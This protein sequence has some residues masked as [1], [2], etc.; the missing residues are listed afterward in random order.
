MYASAGS[1]EERIDIFDL[2]TVVGTPPDD[3][4]EKIGSILPSSIPAGDFGL[5]LSIAVDEGNGHVFVL[6][7]ENCHL[8]EFEADGAYLTTIVFPFVC[9]FGGEIGVDNGPFSPNGKLSEGAGKSRYLYVPSHK[10]GIGHSFAFFESTQGPPEVKST[11]VANLGEDEA[12]LQALIDPN[13][14]QS[15]YVFEYKVEGTESWTP[16][17]GGTIAAS[18]L[19]AE[20]SAAASGLSAGTSYRFRVVATNEEGSDEAEGSFLTYPSVITETSPCPNAPLRS[21]SSALLPDCRAY[22]L[23]TPA[24]TNAHAPLGGRRGQPDPPGLP[25][26]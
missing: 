7:G 12:E 8:Y 11:A 5:Q 16:L 17:G 14:L 25:G 3:E 6:D 15:T 24:D 19:D 13:N 10:S 21:G 4:Y 2:N 1:L 23:V 20:A 18:N 22:E 9:T 26:G